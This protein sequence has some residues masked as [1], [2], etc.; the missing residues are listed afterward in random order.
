MGLCIETESSHDRSQKC[1]KETHN[2]VRVHDRLQTMGDGQKRHVPSELG[3][4][5]PLDDGVRL[6]VYKGLCQHN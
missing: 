4:E 1:E 6:I 5:R 3:T 2:L